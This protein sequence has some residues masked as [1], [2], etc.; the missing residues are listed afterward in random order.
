MIQ[1]IKPANKN[2]KNRKFCFT[3]VEVTVAMLV[4]AI[5]LTII[6]Q[7][8]DSAQKSWSLSSGK[9]TIYENARIA[10]GLINRQIQGIYYEDGVVP[11][12]HKGS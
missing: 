5:L 4:L 7:F 11:F 6:M 10:L 9:S 3:I 2:T 12:Y 8:F 1:E